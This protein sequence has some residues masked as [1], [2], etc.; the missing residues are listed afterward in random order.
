MVEKKS[1]KSQGKQ[2]YKS[3]KDKVIDGVCSG[4]AEYLGVDTTLVR[5]LWL[6][7]LLMNGLGLIAYIVAMILIPVNPEHQNLKKI[8]KD[9]KNPALLWGVLLIVLGLIFLSRQIGWHYDWHFPF[10]YFHFWNVPWKT[11]WPLGLVLL[12]ILY[13]IHVIR[14]DNVDQVHRIDKD[15]RRLFRKKE[16]KMI[17]GVCGGIGEY[18]NVDVTIVRIL[19]V[20]LAFATDIIV[21]IILYIILIIGLPQET[22]I[23]SSKS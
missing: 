9:T 4:L 3:R 18:L 16:T 22:V 7:S 2:L 23:Q 12:G 13:I 17:A 20:L 5:I 15:K 14:S 6:L 10:Q 8:K 1:N 11:V 21:W 19:F